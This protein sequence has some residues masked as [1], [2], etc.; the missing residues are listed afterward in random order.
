ML[1][2]SKFNNSLIVHIHSSFLLDEDKNLLMK[3]WD[4]ANHD[5][6][7]SYAQVPYF[8]TDTSTLPRDANIACMQLKDHRIIGSRFSFS[9]N[10]NNLHSCIP[11]N[12][13]GNPIQFFNIDFGG[14]LC[15]GV[16]TGI[17]TSFK[18]ISG[19][20]PVAVYKRIK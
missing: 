1:F 4:V 14:G 17:T 20:Y 10:T 5:D 13:I 3:N 16:L 18:K 8:A 2:R 12:Q 15:S 19:F 9:K 6:S 11:T 7:A